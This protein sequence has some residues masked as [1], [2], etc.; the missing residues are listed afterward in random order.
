LI[1]AIEGAVKFFEQSI[2]QKTHYFHSWMRWAWCCE[3]LFNANR[4]NVNYALNAI[5]G[6]SECVKLRTESS[7][8]ELLPMISLFFCIELDDQSYGL[9]A[10][11]IGTLNE[12]VLLMILPQM[13]A[14]LQKD[15]SR[16]STFVEGLVTRLLPKHF[17][18]L[19]YPLLFIM[20]LK[21]ATAIHIFEVFA[22][23]NPPA[24]QQTRILS[25]G[26]L[27][28]SCSSLET[29]TDVFTKIMQLTSQQ[30][31]AKAQQ[32]LRSAIELDPPPVEIRNELLKLP[33]ISESTSPSVTEALRKLNVRVRTTLHSIRTVQM[34]EV[35]PELAQLRNS[36]L[37]VPGTYSMSSP[38][39][40]IAQ[41]DPT[42]DIF[43][44]KQRPRFVMIDGVDGSHHRSLLK[45]RSDLRLDQR[46]M[47]FFDLVNQ[48]ISHDF[49]QDSRTMHI[50]TYSITPLSPSSG[51]IQFVN[52]ADTMYSLIFDYRRQR[53]VPVFNEQQLIEAAFIRHSDLLLPIQR[54]EA[55]QFVVSQTPDIDL[56][57]S[58]WL[59]SPGATEWISRLLRFTGS[60]AVMSI[61]GY[62][63]GLG[64]RHPSNL[65][66]HRFTG[67]VIHIDFSD[68]FEVNRNRI[69]FPELVPFQLTRMIRRAF[70]AIGIEGEYRTTCEQ[71]VTLVRSHHDSIAAVLDI[72]LQ[73][74][75]NLADEGG[76]QVFDGG[77]LDVEPLSSFSGSGIERKSTNIREALERIM[78]KITGKDCDADEEMSVEGQVT[79]LIRQATDMYNLAKLYHGWTPLW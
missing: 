1:P 47:L 35:A 24:A 69:R 45:G 29:W 41:F 39:V 42:L 4:T 2:A 72:F 31:Y 26:L 22:Q 65:M 75:L 68:C 78:C 3:V 67:S 6:F 55:L 37:A 18:V 71:T 8:S 66:V 12:G 7:L 79:S 62:V 23:E 51:L 10:K 19:L 38:I 15:R 58:L 48:H 59:A 13:F 49:R 74:P 33:A 50:F 63:L 14:Q 5:N 64:D 40:A 32:L 9:T 46:V 30:Q 70:G 43:N 56:W 44:S 36:V 54:L 21:S 28:C 17:H 25:D 60:S 76:E 27:L 52:G 57:E 11:R 34:H 61:I 77:E 53:G 20:R 16:S 73:E